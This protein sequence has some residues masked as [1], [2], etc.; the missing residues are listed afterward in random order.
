MSKWFLLALLL[1]PGV[2]FV[3]GQSFPEMCPGTSPELQA[4]LN[5][6]AGP[7]WV[8]KEVC[9]WPEGVLKGVKNL[10]Q[11]EGCSCSKRRA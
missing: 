8:G 4:Q 9:F 1:T 3:Q 2:A 11:K 7:N 5:R 6:L 10:A